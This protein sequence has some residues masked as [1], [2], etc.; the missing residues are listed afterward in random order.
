MPVIDFLKKAGEG[1]VVWVGG[2]FLG[3]PH[4]G[5]MGGERCGYIVYMGY[6]N[7]VCGKGLS[8]YVCINIILFICENKCSGPVMAE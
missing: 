8:M 1:V 2:V 7:S 5:G 4:S 6:M 3:W